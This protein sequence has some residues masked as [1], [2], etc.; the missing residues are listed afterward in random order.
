MP[1]FDK[2]LGSLRHVN[3]VVLSAVSRMGASAKVSDSASRT[4]VT[5]GPARAKTVLPILQD[6]C[7]G[8]SDRAHQLVHSMV[9]NTLREAPTLL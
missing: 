4:T 9:I 2:S 3:H 6:G 8:V 7:N 1:P 5:R